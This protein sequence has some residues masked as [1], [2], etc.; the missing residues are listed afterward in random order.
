MTDDTQD[1]VMDR[2]TVFANGQDA[3][4]RIQ[5]ERRRQLID[6]TLTVIAENGISNVTL[7]KVAGRAGLT[8]AMINFHFAGKDSLLLETLRF[9]SNEFQ[10]RFDTA[11]AGS[12]GNAV[13]ALNGIIDTH[14]DPLLSDP[15]RLAVWYAFWGES[16]ARVEYQSLCGDADIANEVKVRALFEQVV[17][18]EGLDGMDAEALS[19][20]FLGMLEF[21]SQGLLIDEGPRERDRRKRQCQ[22]F[23]TSIFPRSFGKAPDMDKPPPSRKWVCVGHIDDL[24]EGCAPIIEPDVN[25]VT[26]YVRRGAEG[27]IQ[28][29]RY[30]EN[31]PADDLPF[32][33]VRL[34]DGLI[35][36]RP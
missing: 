1:T 32:V 5:A 31:C 17:A 27:Q 15:R 26:V 35:F 22:A 16:R 11:I 2:A 8:A 36:V 20:A 19:L 30:R 18:A 34:S 13:R 25:G 21:Q 33:Q 24:I 9:V 10:E 4:T 28:A 7:A 6:A 29:F 23:L 3:N 12:K 14:F